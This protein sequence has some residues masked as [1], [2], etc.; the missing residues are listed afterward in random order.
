MNAPWENSSDQSD[1]EDSKAHNTQ[2]NTA[3]AGIEQHREIQIV[4]WNTQAANIQLVLM[5]ETIREQGIDAMLVQDIRLPERD[6][7]RPP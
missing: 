7:G 5:A 2:H 4:H 6:D 3:Q 1:N